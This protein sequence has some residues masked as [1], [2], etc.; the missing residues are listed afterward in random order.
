MQ[1]PWGG[2]DARVRV[3]PRRRGPGWS[4]HT[5]PAHRP[6]HRRRTVRI[7]HRHVARRLRGQLVVVRE[8]EHV[9][10]GRRAGEA[11]RH[12]PHRLRRA[13]RRCR[14]G[15]PVRPGRD[16]HR[17]ARRRDAVQAHGGHVAPAAP[18]DRVEA[19]RQREGVGVHD[20][21]GRQVARRLAAHRRR[22]RRDDEDAERPEG[23]LLGPVGLQRRAVARRRAQGRRPDRPLHARP[24]LRRLPVHGLGRQLQLDHPAGEL[25]EGLVLQGRDR[26]G[27][28]RPEDPHPQAG[29]DV[30]REPELV[31]EGRQGRQAAVPRRRA[32]Q[33]LQ[34]PAVD[35]ARPAVGRRRHLPADG[36]RD[37]TEPVQRSQRERPDAA[38]ERAPDGRH[39]H[40][41]EAVRRQARAA[42]A[43]VVDRPRGAR[44]GPVRRQ[45]EGRQRPHVRAGLP[46]RPLGFR[47][48]PAPAGLREGQA[49]PRR[50]RPCERD[51]RPD[52]HRRGVPRR[53]R[54]RAAHPGPGQGRR[55]QHQAPP[56]EPVD[57]LQQGLAADAVRHR[58][59]G[60]AREHQPA[61]R[62]GVHEE[63]DLELLALEEHGLRQAR[64]PVRRRGRRGQAQA[65]RRPGREDPERRD[66]DADQLLH[67]RPARGAQERAGHRERPGRPHG[68]LEGLAVGARRQAAAPIGEGAPWPGS[69]PSGSGCR[70]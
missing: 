68:R 27:A 70:S 1:V 30:R 24:R 42:G 59:L 21:P 35:R 6:R 33:V 28:I 37:G 60:R 39:A 34:R 51:H 14:P 25:Q 44:Q 8:Q 36:L 2:R 20:P 56:G 16:L 54:V 52:A 15:V 19:G 45:R 31:G 11:R 9:G 22:R 41:S 63:G 67:H 4:P 5:S 10:R 47:G 29:R 32:G 69:S 7:D 23:R 18:G 40:R 26:D 62:A 48:A 43:R 66:A 13:H 12:V 46:L 53:A 64:R 49:A 65:D 55:H 38:L 3:P 58:R 57:L 61:H 17:P 50:R